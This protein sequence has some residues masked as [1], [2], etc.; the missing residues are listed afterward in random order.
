MTGQ[1]STRLAQNRMRHPWQDRL[2]LAG[3]AAAG[4]LTL[5]VIF[6]VLSTTWQVMA[7]YLGMGAT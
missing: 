6:V 7:P 2:I 4:L 1:N 5:R 3:I